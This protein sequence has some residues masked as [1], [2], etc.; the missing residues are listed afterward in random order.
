MQDIKPFEIDDVDDFK[1]IF[2]VMEHPGN[3]MYSTG[4]LGSTVRIILDAFNDSSIILHGVN[5]VK[6]G[7]TLIYSLSELEQL[8]DFKVAKITN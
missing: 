8:K 4:N 3:L 6:F 1:N 7:Y 5:N 2:Y